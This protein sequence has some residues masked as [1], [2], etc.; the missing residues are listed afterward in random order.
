MR[1]LHT[2]SASLSVWYLCGLLVL[3]TINALLLPFLLLLLL[4]RSSNLKCAHLRM[5]AGHAMSSVNGVLVFKW[6]QKSIFFNYNL[7]LAPLAGRSDYIIINLEFYFQC[8]ILWKYG[9][10]ENTIQTYSKCLFKLLKI[11]KKKN[12][13]FCKKLKDVTEYEY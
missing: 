10:A 6:K 13:A 5:R 4:K 1:L 11:S 3:F 12:F 2:F 8:E 9:N 7:L